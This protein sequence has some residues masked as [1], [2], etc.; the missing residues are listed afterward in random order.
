MVPTGRLVLQ[1]NFISV[2][3][4]RIVCYEIMLIAY[5]ELNVLVSITQQ[6]DVER[7]TILNMV[8]VEIIVDIIVIALVAAASALSLRIM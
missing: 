6:Y 4:V 8:Y 3:A 7:S 1:R 2:G 5:L